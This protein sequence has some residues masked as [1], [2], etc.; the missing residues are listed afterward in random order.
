VF[1]YAKD[2]SATLEMTWW[3]VLTINHPSTLRV[4]TLFV[5]EG[6]RCYAPRF[7]GCAQNDKVECLE[8]RVEIRRRVFA[9]AKDFSA[10]LSPTRGKGVGEASREMTGRSS[11]WTDVKNPFT[12]TLRFAEF[13][14]RWGHL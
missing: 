14:L 10:T 5:K 12:A 4:A 3:G 6:L 7:F 9:Y 13:P 11:V 1:A 8:L 2:F